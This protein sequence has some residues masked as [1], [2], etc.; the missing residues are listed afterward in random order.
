MNTNIYG[1]FQIC[2]SVPLNIFP[3]ELFLKLK[4]FIDDDDDDDE[5]LLW[6]GWPTK[7]V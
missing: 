7:G 3:W 1:D 5:L 6:Y 2:I 4:Y